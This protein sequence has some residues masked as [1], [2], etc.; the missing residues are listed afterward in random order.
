MQEIK[1]DYFRGIEAEQYSFYRV[2]KVLFTAECF[3][4][5]SCEAKVLFGLMLDRMSLSMKNH[6]LDKTDKVYIIFTVEDVMELLSCSRQK[7]VKILA[8]LDTEKGIGL[9]EKKRQGLGKPNIIYVKNFMLKKVSN[10]KPT[11]KEVETSETIQKYE[12]HT[13]ASMESELQEVPEVGLQKYENH[14]PT[15]TESEFPEVPK[16]YFKKCENHTTGSMK[17]ILQEVPESNS[18]Y[19]D[20]NKTE[21]SDTESNETECSKTEYPYGAI[22]S[23]PSL[24]TENQANGVMDVMEEMDTYREI[25]HRNI[26]YECFQDREFYRREE[27]DELV[28]LMVEVMM[29]PDNSSVRIE[30]VEKP[31]AIV[32]NRFMKLKQS[33]IEYVMGCL[34]KNTSKVVNIKAY[35]LTA[36]Y[37]S[38]LTLDNYYHAEVNHDLYGG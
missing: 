30:G 31:V 7:A 18:N 36:L 38:A 17:T 15:S 28:E 32:K 19:T 22:L 14:T 16:S 29:R 25:I 11:E 4:V 6:W 33:H 5:L 1:F 27:V 23:N 13:P 2:P 3:K 24:F 21:Y 8:E 34:Q 10:P 26:D 35:L 12:N 37:N 20:N 9:I